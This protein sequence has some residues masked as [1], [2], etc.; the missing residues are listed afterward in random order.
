MDRSADEGDCR[1]GGDGVASTS[2]DDDTV[3]G[4]GQRPTSESRVGVQCKN[5][6]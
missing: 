2:D 4:N 6:E 1:V 3:G 5:G